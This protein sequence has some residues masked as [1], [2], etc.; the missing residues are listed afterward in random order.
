MLSE[1]A[2]QLEISVMGEDLRNVNTP[3]APGSNF[4]RDDI[5]VA[6]TGWPLRSSS[7]VHDVPVEFLA[8][9]QRQEYWDH[10]DFSVDQSSFKILRTEPRCNS[11]EPSE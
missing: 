7:Q 6:A 5:W 4:E 2:N 10:V 8:L 3:N 11:A 9:V 1:M